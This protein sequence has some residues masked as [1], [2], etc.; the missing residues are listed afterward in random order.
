MTKV[1]KVFTALSVSL[2]ATFALYSCTSAVSE[3]FVFKYRPKTDAEKEKFNQLY[4]TIYRQKI[5]S[6][7]TLYG[8]MNTDINDIFMEETDCIANNLA[9]Y[10]YALESKA[11][12]TPGAAKVKNWQGQ[13]LGQ[14]LAI[15]LSCQQ[16]PGA[17][18]PRVMT[19]D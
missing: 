4:E 18:P 7:L 13:F 19:L 12:E 14:S 16:N 1:K 10:Q 11:Q 15:I 17:V 9:L 2:A 8:A 5:A 6:A 3:D